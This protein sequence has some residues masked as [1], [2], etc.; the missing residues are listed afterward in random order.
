MNDK[1]DFVIHEHKAKKAGLHYDLRIKI[2]DAL[3]DWVFRKIP[4]TEIGVK[5]LGFEQPE[6][7]A[8]WLDFEGIIEEGYGAGELNIWDRGKVEIKIENND[9]IICNFQGKKMHGQ[10]ILLNNT[11]LKGWLFWKSE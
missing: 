5:R 11:K 7:N 8:I 4:P 3:K 2:G 9:K 10:Y 6:H 1:T